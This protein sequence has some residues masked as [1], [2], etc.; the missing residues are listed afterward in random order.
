MTQERNN[1]RYRMNH[2]RAAGVLADLAVDRQLQIEILHVLDLVGGQHIRPHRTEPV[3]PFAVE[4]VVE[5]V[6]WPFG[7]V[8]LESHRP[9]RDIVDNGI[10]GDYLQGILRRYGFGLS[11]DYDRKF[12]FV[13][14][15]LAVNGPG[16]RKP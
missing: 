1:L 6:P 11:A 12:E 9:C 10:A 4:P 5:L 7:T 13:V 14:Y 16:Y 8:L 2:L 3:G 15:R